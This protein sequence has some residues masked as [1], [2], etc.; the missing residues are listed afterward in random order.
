VTT[1]EISDDL[2]APEVVSDPHGYYRRIRET[3]P[4]HRRMILTP[5]VCSSRS[6]W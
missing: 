5:R 3:D 2:L 4:V 6:G 1:A